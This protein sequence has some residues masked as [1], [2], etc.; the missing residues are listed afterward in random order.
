MRTNIELDQKLV[1]EAPRLSRSKT[2]R[3]LVHPALLEFV[4]SRKRLDIRELKGSNLID[5]DYDYKALRQTGG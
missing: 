2:K 5:E 3:A 1:R 4:A